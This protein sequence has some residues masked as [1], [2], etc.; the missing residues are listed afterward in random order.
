M[1]TKGSWQRAKLNLETSVSLVGNSAQAEEWRL[2]LSDYSV[3]E[4][5]EVVLTNDDRGHQLR[6]FSPV[7]GFLSQAEQSEVYPHLSEDMGC[8]ISNA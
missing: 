1:L 6:L 5:S 7:R 2:L 8:L 4:I 3:P